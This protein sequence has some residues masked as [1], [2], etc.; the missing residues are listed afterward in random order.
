[1][2]GAAAVGM[3]AILHRTYEE[4]VAELGTLLGVQLRT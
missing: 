1:M 2:T 4:T 3:V